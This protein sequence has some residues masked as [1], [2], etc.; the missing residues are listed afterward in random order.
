M[1]EKG[2]PSRRGWALLF[3]LILTAVLLRAWQ[4]G[5]WPP[6]LYRDEA[7]NGLDA[8]DVLAGK[9]ALFFPANNGREPLYIYLTAVAIHFFGRTPFAVRLAAA[10][11]GSVTTLAVWQLGRTWFDKQSGWFAAWLWATMFWPVHLSRIGLR[12]ILMPLF[13]ALSL[14]LA[15]LA[16]RRR[17]WF[18]WLIA[19]LVYGMGYYTYLAFRF[20][21]VLLLVLAIW[22]AWRGHRRDLWPGVMWF[23]V[24]TAVSLLP[25]LWLIWQNPAL[26]LGRTGQVSIFNPTINH[27]DFWGTLF[28]HIGRGLGMFLWRGDSILRHNAAGRPVF[29]PLMSVPF[30][31]GLVWCFRNWKRPFAL[32]PLLWT[33]TMLGPTIFAEDTPHFLRATGVLPGVLFLPAIGLTQLWQWPTLPSRLRQIG[34]ILLC[35]GSLWLTVRDYAN[36]SRQPDVA[37]LFETAATELAHQVNHEAGETAVYI[38]NRYWSGWPSIPF[39]VN[40]PVHIFEPENAPPTSLPLPASIYTWPYAT[41]EYLPAAISPPILI[42]AEAGPLAR[43]DL[44]PAPYSLYT[45][46]QFTPIQPDTWPELARFEQNI[47]LHR[48]EKTLLSPNTLQVTLYW[49]GQMPPPVTAFVHVRNNANR[50][51]GQSD[52]PPAEGHWAF[53]WWQPGLIIRDQHLIQLNESVNP[54]SES[55]LANLKIL[56]G[57]YYPDTLE[58]LAVLDSDNNVVGDTYEDNP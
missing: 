9:H 28:R 25:L 53:G 1:E 22:L 17:H 41:R 16:C 30:V 43:G 6:G 18:L 47:R 39:L 20:T 55:G 38:D 57:L 4:L 40:R 24:G 42:T 21:P 45:R 26:F 2:S 51:I 19:G 5:T 31:V 3:I 7:F 8:L 23:G 48:I 46:Y 15:T 49:Q 50:L 34:V 33:L 29:D 11:V 10:V 37:Y 12:P 54:N 35:G 56:V 13:L 58:R 27:G 14:W 36:Y 44:E 52:H 32:L